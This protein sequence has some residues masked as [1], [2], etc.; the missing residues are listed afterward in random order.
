MKK[1]ASFREITKNFDGFL[2]DAFGVLVDEGGLLPGAVA[3]LEHLKDV[4]KP[5]LML[6]NGSSRTVADTAQRYRDLGLPFRD[7]QV[8]TSGG[9]LQKFLVEETE[10]DDKFAVMGTPGS[11]QLLT[12]TG[13]QAQ[14]VLSAKGDFDY[15]IIANQ[16]D[17]PLL[18]SID[19]ALTQVCSKI[20]SGQFIRV[21]LTNPDLFYPR[22]AG[23]LGI[24]AGSIAEILR[25]VS[26][27]A[28]GPYLLS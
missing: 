22:K 15:L 14:D 19:E 3:A 4:E 13:R 28:T 2:F 8:I 5:Y 25:Q 17:Y 16:T 12:E 6:S 7:D 24:T 18:P 11:F 21:V 1:I 20:D 26:R 10:V 23:A 27:L 9:M